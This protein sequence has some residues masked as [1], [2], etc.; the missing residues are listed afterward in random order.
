MRRLFSILSVLVLLPLISPPVCLAEDPVLVKVDAIGQSPIIKGNVEKSRIGALREA[1][2]LAVKQKSDRELGEM[3]LQSTIINLSDIVA[4]RSKGLVKNYVIVKEGISERDNNLYSVSIEAMVVERGELPPEEHESLKL[5]LE[6][7]DNPRILILIPED[8]H[9]DDS[10]HQSVD[11]DMASTIRSF[12]TALAHKFN[13]YGY[14]VVTSDDLLA[15]GMSRPETLSQAKAGVTARAVEVARAAN[16]DLVLVGALRMAN[17]KTA[18]HKVDL[19]MVTGEISLKAIIVSSGNL[20]DAIHH[21]VQVSHPQE[22]KARSDCVNKAAE[23]VGQYLAWKIPLM[24]SKNYRETELVIQ[25][26]DTSRAMALQNLLS[27]ITGVEKIRMKQLPTDESKDAQYVVITGFIAPEPG[28]I[29]DNCNK[30]M[31]A[32]MTL[33]D[34]N[35]YEITCKMD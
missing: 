9:A 31:Q 13:F 5:Y 4:N 1:Y 6:L 11:N 34:S 18:V 33:V 3:Q 30:S 21:N 2:T 7:L 27:K 16:V 14:Q 29:I 35:K 23:E 20:I 22:L 19:N 17:E 12:E 28:E 15:Q 24:L 8:K 10:H 32:T 26:V 25:N